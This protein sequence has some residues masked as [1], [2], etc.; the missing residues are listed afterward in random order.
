MRVSVCECVC[1]GESPGH[2]DCRGR[3]E[4]QSARGCPPLCPGLCVSARGCPPLCP[5]LCVSA[6][7]LSPRYREVLQVCQSL[8][9]CVKAGGQVLWTSD[10]GYRLGVIG[11]QLLP[12]SSYKQAVQ[13]PAP[14]PHTPASA[15]APVPLTPAPAPAP[16]T[17]APCS[18]AC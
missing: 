3:W 1:G 17:P 10:E 8:C 7:W 9:L 12:H 5:S 15:P 11:L 18:L 4:S 14:A 13:H 16:L 6:P 2:W